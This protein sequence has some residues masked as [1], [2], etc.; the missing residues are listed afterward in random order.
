M[1]GP[2]AALIENLFASWVADTFG[3]TSMIG[4]SIAILSLSALVVYWHVKQR[5]AKKEGMASLP[6]IIAA[7]WIAALAI[8]AGAYGLGLR[9]VVNQA[10]PASLAPPVT[11]SPATETHAYYS[12]AQKDELANRISTIYQL[13]NKDVINLS[14]RWEKIST[15]ATGLPNM[16]KQ[17]VEQLVSEIADTKRDTIETNKKIWEDAVNG[18]VDLS[19]ELRTLVAGNVKISELISAEEPLSD[20]VSLYSQLYDDLEARQLRTKYGLMLFQYSGHL[21]RAAMAL[22]TWVEECDDRIAARRKSL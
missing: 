11:S 12:T 21:Q 2:L 19:T 3:P 22:K 4:V 7:F 17:Q 10:M 6:F 15:P 5:R 13:L 1:F 14:Q 16:T 8:G 9:A 18:N 20:A